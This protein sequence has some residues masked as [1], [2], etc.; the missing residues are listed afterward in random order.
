MVFLA[1]KTFAGPPYITDDPEPVEY[2]HWEVYLASIFAKQPDAW[3]STAPHVEVN[4]GVVPDVQL[5]TILPLTLYAPADGA[6]SYGYG[7]TELGVKFR[8]V[9][10]GASRPQIGIF[11][12]LEVPPPKSHNGNLGSP[13]LQAFLPLWLQKS[14]GKWTVY[15]GGGYWINPGAG[16]RNW[17][18]NGIVIQRQ[19]LPN[20]APG[21]ELFHGTSQQAGQSEQTGFNLGMVWDLS[22][23][24]HIMFSAGPAFGGPNQLQ[25]YFAYQLTFGP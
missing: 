8:F 15:G 24:Q 25:G 11:P 16:N 2:Q 6:S 10:E 18:F 17:W 14:E 5:H 20:L 13:R 22:D 19:I 3:T 1:P 7:V 23:L 21:L 4:Y 9:Q 12:L